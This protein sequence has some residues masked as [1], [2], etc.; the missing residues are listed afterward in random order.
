MSTPS[1]QPKC[2]KVGHGLSPLI[3]MELTGPC[4]ARCR[5][6]WYV[7]LPKDDLAHICQCDKTMNETSGTVSLLLWIRAQ[8]DLL[9]RDGNQQGTLRLCTYRHWVKLA[10]RDLRCELSSAPCI[11]TQDSRWTSLQVRQSTPGRRLHGHRA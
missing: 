5:L 8:P 9:S 10:C 11:C 4:N 1:L 3:L 2:N 6:Y 7:E